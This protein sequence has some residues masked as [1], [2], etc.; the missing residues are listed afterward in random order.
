MN[1]EITKNSHSKINQNPFK[2]GFLSQF[3]LNL[4]TLNLK[5]VDIK[6]LDNELNTFER[7]SL[8]LDIE[9]TLISKNELL[10]SFAISN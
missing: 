9:K 5:D 1:A 7:I 10:A 4:D 2:K 6:S 3:S 8:D